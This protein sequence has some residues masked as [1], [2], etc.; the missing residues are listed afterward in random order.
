MGRLRVLKGDASGLRVSGQG[1][2]DGDGGPSGHVALSRNCPFLAPVGGHGVRGAGFREGEREGEKER[3]EVTSSST[4]SAV[5][6]SVS[7]PVTSPAAWKIPGQA[8]PRQASLHPNPSPLSPRHPHLLPDI[9]G[10]GPV[11]VLRELACR[12]A[13]PTRRDHA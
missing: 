3:K 1:L 2:P 10:R 8:H 9:S 11:A 7:R 5:S 13:S 6:Q 4:S 12:C